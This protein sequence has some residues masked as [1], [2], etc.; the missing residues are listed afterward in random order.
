[1]GV[2]HIVNKQ[3]SKILTPLK[4]TDIII[5]LTFLKIRPIDT[6]EMTARAPRLLLKCTFARS[7]ERILP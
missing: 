1:M 3:I 5:G 6:L 7:Y 2:D 4:V